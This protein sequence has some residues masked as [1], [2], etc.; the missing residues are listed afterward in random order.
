MDHCNKGCEP[1]SWTD[2]ESTVSQRHKLIRPMCADGHNHGYDL[3][4]RQ[5]KL[6]DTP[7][8]FGER[9]RPM[10]IEVVRNY[11]IG[12]GQYRVQWIESGEQSKTKQDKRYHGSPHTLRFMNATRCYILIT[13]TLNRT[14][15][16]PAY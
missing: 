2:T 4:G 16:G 12:A 7:S 13:S 6:S 10:E 5:R 14:W 8:P 3:V 1:G 15:A 11:V 9:S